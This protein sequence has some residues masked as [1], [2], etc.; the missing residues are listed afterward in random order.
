[1]K[2]VLALMLLLC[3]ALTQADTLGFEA[4]HGIKLMASA[5]NN[6]N[7][8][9]VSM[10]K[11]VSDNTYLEFRGGHLNGAAVISGSLGYQLNT[12][13]Q[14]FASV[15]AAWVEAPPAGYLTGTTQF[16][17]STGVRFW[18]SNRY[19]FEVAARHLSNGS[20]LGLGEE[21]NPGIDHILFGIRCKL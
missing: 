13:L 7:N 8:A 12:R 11:E 15:G 4:G 19:A 10:H 6:F 17:L 5:D 2:F 9:A 1:M 21:P 3:P 16:L 14:P 20:D 18:F